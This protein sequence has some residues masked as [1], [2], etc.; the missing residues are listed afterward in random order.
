VVA[1]RIPLLHGFFFGPD[2]FGTADGAL[3]C[4]S[5]FSHDVYL[6]FV[7]LTMLLELL[8][9]PWYACPNFSHD[10]YPAR[11]TLKRHVSH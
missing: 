6:A 2:A 11:V 8:M 1:Q 10:V 5:N 3:L 4:W 9:E 7:N